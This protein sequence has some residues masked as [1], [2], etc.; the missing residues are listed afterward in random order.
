MFLSLIMKMH[1]TLYY[2][3]HFYKQRQAEIGKKPSKSYAKSFTQNFWYLK[4]IHILHPKI[5]G[6]ILENKQKNRCVYINEIM[7]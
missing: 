2:K 7:R 1:Y 5:I 3:K 4:I 6:H